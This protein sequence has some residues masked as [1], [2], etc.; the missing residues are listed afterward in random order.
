ML[1]IKDYLPPF[2]FSDGTPE[3]EPLPLIVPISAESEEVC[4]PPA[5]DP[6]SAEPEE[7]WLPP[8]S[9]PVAA[10]SEEI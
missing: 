4:L 8:A 3:E 6:V 9:D 1:M 5:S 7:V 2:P 10:E